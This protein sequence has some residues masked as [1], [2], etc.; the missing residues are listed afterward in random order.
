MLSKKELSF[1]YYLMLPG[2][3]KPILRL[4]LASQY[5]ILASSFASFFLYFINISRIA[6]RTALLLINVLLNKI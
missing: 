1:S 5:L 2:L 3:R 6:D 4:K